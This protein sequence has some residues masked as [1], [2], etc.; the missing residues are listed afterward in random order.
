MSLK[1]QIQKATR[2]AFEAGKSLQAGG[3]QDDGKEL[4]LI[5]RG[6]M[7]YDTNSGENN[8]PEVRHKISG[9]FSAFKEEEING[10]TVRPEDR[11]VVL[12]KR[13]T[14]VEPK[15]SDKIEY[16]KEE[17]SIFRVKLVQSD[18]VYN[19]HLRNP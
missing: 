10:L 18:S 19:L 13:N 8:V 17:W 6:K 14:P 1:H 11:R 7:T 9:F 2:K 5:E 3:V 15:L 12:E 16:D 4:F